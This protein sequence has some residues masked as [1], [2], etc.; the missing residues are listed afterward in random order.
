VGLIEREPGELVEH[1]LHEGGHAEY[2]EAYRS[3]KKRATSA[4][5]VSAEGEHD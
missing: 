1:S 4:L 3:E 2:P 5:P